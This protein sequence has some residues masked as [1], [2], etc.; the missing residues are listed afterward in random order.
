MRNPY[1]ESEQKNDIMSTFIGSDRGKRP[2]GQ[3]SGRR[4]E[5]NKNYK[6]A[7]HQGQ[8]D[9]FDTSPDLQLYQDTVLASIDPK[10]VKNERFRQ[11]W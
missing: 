2:S 11:S 9:T 10:T 4:N 3:N 1:T 6:T 7:E 5:M 8:R